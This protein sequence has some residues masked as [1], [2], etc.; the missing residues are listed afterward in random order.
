M[1][2]FDVSDFVYLQQQLND[3]LDI[4]FDRNIL[5]IKAIKLSGV[6]KLQ[7]ANRCTIRDHSKNYA[8][9]HLPN[10][11]STIIMLIWIPP[12]DYPC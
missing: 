2:Q 7:G 4:F 12:L 11:D 6:L 5:R 8:P 10:L 3:T 9:C 1:R